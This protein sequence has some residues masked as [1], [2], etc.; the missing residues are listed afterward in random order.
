[1]ETPAKLSCAA[2]GAL[3]V[4]KGQLLLNSRVLFPGKPSGPTGQSCSWKR[5]E[6][7]G[8]SSLL[9]V[10]WQW[11]ETFQSTQRESGKWELLCC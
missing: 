5:L 10:L 3:L 6:W 9:Q 4:I 11:E 7:D 1:M 8:I 2:E